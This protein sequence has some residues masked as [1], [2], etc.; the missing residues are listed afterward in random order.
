MD[1]RAELALRDALAFAESIVDT[2]RDPL[3]VLDAGLRVVTASREF[4]RTFGVTPGATEGRL[5]Y[6]L[7]NRQWDIPRLRTLLEEILPQHTTFRDFEVEHTFQHIGRKVML[8]NARTLYRE[9]NNTKRIVL[10]IEDVTERRDAEEARRE[11]E[12]RFTEM[13]KNVRDHSIF[14]TDPAGVIT[15]WNVAAE[16]VIGYPEAEAVGKHFS[17]I[18]T[19]EDREN[20]LPDW[21]LRAAR[22]RGRAEDERWHVRKGGERFWALGIVTPLHDASGRLTG[23]SKILRDITDR[24]RAADALRASEAKYRTL[25]DSMDE[26]FCIIEVLSEDG[27]PADYRFLEVN[28]AFERQTG[29]AGAAGRRMREI[30]P[31]H[32]EHWFETYGRVAASGEPVRFQHAAD[33]LGR[34]YDVYA[35]RV[36]TPEQRR[37][38]I[39][40]N[41]ITAR[42]RAEAALRHRT[43]QFQVLLDRAPVGVYLVDADFRIVE[44]N[45]AARPVFGDVPDLVGRDFGEVI[46]TLWEGDYADEVA[47]LFRSTLE[48]GE[49]YVT[50]ERAERR[51]DRGVLEYYE[52]RIDRIT[53]LDG[54]FGVVCYFRDVSERVHRE[55]ALR[56]ADRRKDEFL[57]MLGHELRNPLT[58]L[59]GVVDT[60]RRQTP[61]G[62]GLGRAYAMMDRQVGH[63]TRLVDD[64]LDVSRI[65]RGLV[66]LRREPVGLAEVADQAAEMAAPAVEGRGHEL[67]LTLPRKPLRVEGD[68]TRLTQVLYNLLNNAAKYTDAGGRI[69]L[70]IGREGDEAVV[71]VRDNGSGMKADLVP[72]VFD[73][74]T[75]GERTLDRSLGGLGLGLT[76]VRRLVEMHGG[77]AEARSDGPERGSE[78]IVR[79]PALPADDATPAA[80]RPPGPPRAAVQVARALVID[81]NVDVAESMTWMLEGLA[82]EIKMVHSGP[83]ALELVPEWRPD[84]I[85]CD[86]GMPGM[87]GYETCRRLRR[88]PGLAGVVIAAV[89]GYGGPEDQTK[90][91][92][93]GFDRHLVKPVGWDT[94]ADLVKTAAGAT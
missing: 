43:A 14:L 82:R 17:L 80:P 63:L 60:L 1:E 18:F 49:S 64:L 81:D 92:E 13:V 87:D 89:S 94:V 53:L 58:P 30:A 86:I 68:A 40:F 4:Y 39:L 83:A 76:L 26:G 67:S 25:F 3:L 69:W 54:R 15:S 85:L 61:D 65:T 27:R 12:A 93:A 78:F 51:R 73:L 74:F 84:V 23:F 56:E 66:E 11:T 79:L 50:S 57:A 91:K 70:T 44:V 52:W 22:E 77:T 20:G 29:I 10:V 6:D 31:G 7:G 47:G 32:E 59:R 24:K 72:K 16:R 75:Q 37:V 8:L 19:P 9:Q 28:P 41:D 34:Y 45:P 35:F 71:R 90:S 88:A 33:A 46:H 21:E 42:Q 36:G 2:M 38:A 62:D 55:A 48:T 5:V